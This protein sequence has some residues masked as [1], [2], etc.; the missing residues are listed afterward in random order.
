MFRVTAASSRSG[1]VSHDIETFFIARICKRAYSYLGAVVSGL[2]IAGVT[3][4]LRRRI[5]GVPVDVALG[6]HNVTVAVQRGP[7]RAA[8]RQGGALCW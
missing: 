6:R 5:T 8:A 4:R 3:L 1:D 2:R 7:R